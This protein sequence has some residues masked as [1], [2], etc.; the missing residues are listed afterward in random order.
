MRLDIQALRALAV[1]AVVAYHLEPRILPGGFV[2]VDVFF[3]ISGFLITLHLIEQPPTTGADLVGFWARRIRRLLPASLLVLA[4]SLAATWALLPETRWQSTAEQTRAAALYYVN[5]ALQAD[6]VDYLRMD[7]TPTAVQHFWSLAVE[8][9]FYLLWPVV[10]LALTLFARRRYALGLGIVVAASFAY[11]IYLTTV[12]PAAAYFSTWTRIWELGAGGLMAVAAPSV[13]ARLQSAHL[14]AIG[15]AVA[16]WAAIVASFFLITSRTP[17]PGWAAALPVL[18]AVLV[19]AGNS[20]FR[21]QAWRPV[22]WLGDAS[23]SVYLW[24]WPLLLILPV[25]LENGVGSPGRGMIDNAAIVAATLLLSGLTK[26]LVEDRFRTTRWSAR[27]RLTYASGAVGMAIVVGFAL[28]LHFVEKRNVTAAQ[29]ALESAL[30]SADPCLGAGSLDAELACE[31]ATGPFIPAP[32]LAEG[33]RGPAYAGQN[34]GQDCSSDDDQDYPLIT[35]TLGDP[36]GTFEVALIGNSHASQWAPALVE[37]AELRHW[38]VTTYVAASC[39][40]ADTKPDW[41]QGEDA[42]DDCMRWNRQVLDA[43]RAD[44]PDLVLVSNRTSHTAEGEDDLESSYGL[45]EAG[46]RRTLRHLSAMKKPVVVLRDTPAAEN[47]GLESPPECVATRRDPNDCSGPREE[48]V[49]VDPAV[50]AAEALPD[51]G[52]SVVDLNDYLCTLDTC[53]SVVGGVIV[54]RDHSHMTATF[55][56][57]LAPY[58]DEE[59]QEAV[60]QDR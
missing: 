41:D 11:S 28:T 48:W 54:Y 29:D 20:E 24:H 4:S 40:T 60:R 31:P 33:D 1:A 53:N 32:A 21:W 55:N 27:T 17:F 7:R 19:L 43:L 37:I 59:L 9:Q 22:H 18:G 12:N 56:R 26:T 42:A 3:V 49:P 13:R 34:N 50:A 6:A 2:G 30:A 57:T 38:R 45:W 16:G 52:V 5:W 51:R 36:E 58:L 44:P 47:G 10:I 23:Y 15:V 39:A 46:Y 25:A 8:E 14:A 35:C